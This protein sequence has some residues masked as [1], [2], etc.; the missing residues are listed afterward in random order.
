MGGTKEKTYLDLQVEKL[1]DAPEKAYEAAMREAYKNVGSGMRAVISTYQRGIVDTRSLFNDQY[2]TN[3]GYNPRETIRYRAVDPVLVLDWLKTNISTNVTGVTSYRWGIPTLEEIALE[4]LQDTYVGMNLAEKSFEISGVRWYVS[5]VTS[6]SS[7]TTDATCYK[8]RNVTVAEYVSRN[9]LTVASIADGILT[10]AGVNYWQVTM[11]NGSIVNVKVEYMTIPC[12]GVTS[13]V[14]EG[15]VS[16]YNG[17][18]YNINGS[19]DSDGNYT[20]TNTVTITAVVG[21]S[22]Q[23]EVSGKAGRP[24]I[25]GWNSSAYLAATKEAVAN[26]V[27][28]VRKDIDVAL[29]DSLDRLVAVYTLDG[30]QKLKL[31]EIDK[32]LISSEA[33]ASAFP[34]IPLKENYAFVKENRQMKAVLNKLGMATADFEKSLN[35]EKLKNAAVMFLL[36][37]RDETN[38]GTKVV[39]ETL[40]NMV[41]TTI[42]GS[43]K[44]PAESVYQLNL[45]F[46]DVNMTS[47]V[48][49]S[50]KT[51]AGSIGAVGAYVRF[52]YSETYTVTEEG[53][54]ADQSWTT[55]V[56][57]TGTKYGIRKQVTE[58]YYEELVFGNCKTAWSVGGYQLNGKLRLGDTSGEVYIPITDLGMQMLTYE[59]L[60]YAIARGL[61]LMVLSVTKVK[62]KWY[63]SGFFKFVLV[64]ALVAITIATAGTAAGATAPALAAVLGVSVATATTIAL[65]ITVIATAVSVLGI[66]GVDT[67]V[68]G[69]VAT[70]L[71]LGTAAV[72]A[73]SQVAAG[74]LQQTILT[75]A[76]TLVSMASMAVE[77][78]AKGTIQAMQD[79]L[80]A[81]NKLL[82]ESGEELKKLEESMQ[83]GL[84]M[85]V[86]DRDPELL[87]AM[88]STDTMCNYDVLYD[89]DGMYDRKIRSVGI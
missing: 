10:V 39:Y 21:Y 32:N 34:I 46:S 88:S 5:G 70:V 31:A 28:T 25:N 40:V 68:F 85:G 78:N 69:D 72:G 86:S 11:T 14:V 24:T 52:S 82:E 26:V 4:Y 74:T 18:V 13:A 45:G 44:L 23:V 3:L 41:R 63:Q 59:E 80:A 73:Y 33:N 9:G 30:V 66:M 22:G 55:T 62:T 49:F 89:Y 38:V 64:V 2:L 61:S 29:V 42:P 75:S 43:G 77:L 71:S 58:E 56:T 1:M 7:S 47:K 76:E 87:Y 84:W 51:V 8:D 37:L 57:K 79:K 83:Q 35:N 6:T 81:V 27:D 15:V 48:D 53:G 54:G 16:L 36:D 50:L 17:R 60:H 12:P 67:G 65:T 19:V 20:W